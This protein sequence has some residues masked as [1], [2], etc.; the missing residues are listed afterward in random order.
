M[1]DILADLPDD[2]RD[3]IAP[4][5]APD[6]AML[7][8]I[9]VAIAQKRDEAKTARTSSGIEQLWT[10]AEEAYLGIDDANR[11]EFAAAKWSKPMSSDGPVTTDR[12]PAQP[13]YK[14][15]VFVRL[16]ARYVDAAA[17]KLGEILL[18][19]GDKAFSFSETPV[20]N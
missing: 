3:I 11:H 4:H 19:P 2:V 9:S 7:D 18:P 10:A 1:S 5:I 13:D 17:A 12:K 14:S 6:P 8:A 16:T 20:P 15:T